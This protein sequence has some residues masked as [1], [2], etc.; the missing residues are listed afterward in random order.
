VT[1]IERTPADTSSAWAATTTGRVFVSTDVDAADP[2]VVTWTRIDDDAVTPNRHVSSISVDPTDGNHAW[3]SYNGFNANTPANPGHVFEV[4]FH[5]GTSTATWVDR[6]Y[7]WGDLP[8][9]DVAFDNVTG[10]VY[11]SSD[12]GVSMLPHGT[13]SWVLAA[14]GM[15]SVEVAGLTILPDQRLMYAATH[16]LGAWRLPLP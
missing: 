8:A 6:S 4:T 3:V 9:T 2:G 5:P 13:T 10:D 1:A 14:T 12:F 11:A 7:N 16:G 15:P